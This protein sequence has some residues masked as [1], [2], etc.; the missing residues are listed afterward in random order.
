[1]KQQ[2]GLINHHEEQL[3]KILRIFME[4][5]N[6]GTSLGV[7]AGTVTLCDETIN[8]DILKKSINYLIKN[9][10][11][12]RL[13]FTEVNG[14]PMQYVTEYSEYDIDIPGAVWKDNVYGT[15][16]H[17]EKSGEVG[18]KILGGFLSV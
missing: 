11:G 6:P 13:R 15:Q 3:N 1:M 4:Q 5:F 2:Y 12:L 17:P 18:L 10:D 7:I 14:V 16:F 8:I 9:N